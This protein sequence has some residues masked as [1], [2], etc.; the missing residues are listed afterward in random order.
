MSLDNMRSD[1]KLDQIQKTFEIEDRAKLKAALCRA[2]WL[3]TEKN[4][5]DFREADTL[6]DLE[7]PLDLAIELLSDPLN[8]NRLAQYWRT[9]SS[10]DLSMLPE[11]LPDFVRQLHHIK[12]TALEAHKKRE[13]ERGRLPRHDL[14]AAIEVLLRYWEDDLKRKFTRDHKWARGC[15]RK[16]IKGEP[17]PVTDAERFVC[18]AIDYFT[19]TPNVE[20]RKALRSFSQN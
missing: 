11:Y 20:L 14:H 3:Y 19:P 13:I 17:E 18:A 15:E 8:G 16:S 10:A 2:M 7:K 4:A 12:T 9:L 5:L 6:H 1:S